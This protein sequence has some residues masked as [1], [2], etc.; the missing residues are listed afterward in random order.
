M[1]FGLSPTSCRT[2]YEGSLRTKLISNTNYKV[3]EAV[4]P[5]LLIKAKGQQSVLRMKS[6]KQNKVGFWTWHCLLSPQ[7]SWFVNV[8]PN[9]LQMCSCGNPSDLS[10]IQH[11]LLLLSRNTYLQV[12]CSRRLTCRW[13]GSHHSWREAQRAQSHSRGHFHDYSTY[14]MN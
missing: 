6:N 11:Q 4:C 9:E 13:A 3:L 14:K 8:A 12:A 10:S 5:K 2:L 7:T 1:I